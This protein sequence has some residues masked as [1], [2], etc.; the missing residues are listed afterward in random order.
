MEPTKTQPLE[1]YY[2]TDNP[3]WN[4]YAFQMTCEVIEERDFENEALPLELLSL[5]NEIISRYHEQPLQAVEV[6]NAELDKNSLTPE[7]KSFVYRWVLKYLNASEFDYETSKVKGLLK[8]HY[9]ILRA[10]AEVPRPLVSSIRETLKELVQKELAALPET[11]KSLEPE[12]RLNIVCKLLPFVLPK[13]EAI[14]SERGE[15]G[16]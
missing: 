6:F 2:S 7:Q 5:A 13:V 9:S 16:F 11:L 15:P 3:H 14:H 8:S 12:K 4:T 1:S 10:E